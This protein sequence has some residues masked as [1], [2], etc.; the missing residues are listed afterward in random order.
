MFDY[1]NYFFSFAYII[2]KKTLNF[3]QMNENPVYENIYIWASPLCPSS[4]FSILALIS[5]IFIIIF[6]VGILI[7]TAAFT[8]YERKLMALF[9]RREGPDKIGFEGLGQPFAD[10]LKLVRKETLYPKDTAEQKIF[11]ISPMISFW[12]SLILWSFIPFA[13]NTVIINS[14]VSVL[15]ILGISSIGSYGVIY[16]GWASNNKYALMGA[17]RAVAQFISYEIIF[18]IV[19]LPVL[20]ITSSTNLHT[21]A[22][23]QSTFGSFIYLIPFWFILFIVL[24][25]ES[26]RTPFDLPEAEAELVSGFNVEYSSL[27]FALF[28]LAEYAS[29][30]FFSAFFVTIFFGGW[31]PYLFRGTYRNNDQTVSSYFNSEQ[32]SFSK[33][34]R[35]GHYFKDEIVENLLFD[36]IYV[37][38]NRNFWNSYLDQQYEASYEIE[39][40][41]VI[42]FDGKRLFGWPDEM[43]NYNLFKHNLQKYAEIV[44]EDIFNFKKLSFFMHPYYKNSQT[45]LEPFMMW[46]KFPTKKKIEFERNNPYGNLLF[47][48]E[49]SHFSIDASIFD[50]NTEINLNNNKFSKFRH[51]ISTQPVHNGELVEMTNYSR[52]WL[53][54]KPFSELYILRKNELIDYIVFFWMGFDYTASIQSGE[55]F[56]IFIIALKIQFIT[57]FFIFV[58]ASLPR[59]RF[60]QLINLCWKYLFPISFS[61]AIFFISLY[62]CFLYYHVF[63]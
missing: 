26:N 27:L 15:L 24:L 2:N 22:Q 62:Y 23:F 60:D 44:P 31:S 28:F 37:D 49:E 8:L 18:S 14:E 51:S 20:A 19:I 1:H 43:L 9:Q 40:R 36:E 35:Q 21:I 47:S 16:A 39:D 61:L 5:T 38:L 25:A 30:G 57:T 52:F 45:G 11:F 6:M 4:T 7:F 63:N 56:S 34:D 59:K 3:W 46:F 41:D 50:L 17:F 58:R 32:I 48:D 54:L 53:E 12:V 13:P 29:M 42:P 55:F 10:G 33:T